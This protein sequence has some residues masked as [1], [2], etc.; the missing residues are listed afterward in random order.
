MATRQGTVSHY[1][2]TYAATAADEVIYL[3]NNETTATFVPENPFEFT[4]IY[5]T[6]EDGADD[7]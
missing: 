1:F 3:K 7:G 2:S 5:I 6:Y 4:D